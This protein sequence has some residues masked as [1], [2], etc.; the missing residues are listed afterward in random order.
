LEVQEKPF[1]LKAGLPGM[2]R[3]LIVDRGA[4]VETTGALIQGVWGNGQIDAGML[5]VLASQPDHLLTP[6]QVDVSLRGTVILA[7]YASDPAVLQTAA[8]LPAKGVLLAGMSPDLISVAQELPMPVVVLEGFGQRALNEVAYRLLSTSEQRDVAVNAEPWDHFAGT[9]PEVVIPLPTS[10]A[11]A[12]PQEADTFTEGQQVRIIRAPY[13]GQVGTLE[14]HKGVAALPNGL[15]VPA[16]EI[17]LESG[18]SALVP[19]ANLEV[20][21]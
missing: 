10:G 14:A 1:E 16:A 13:A 12:G 2:V 18:T 7:G 15:R 17:R 8:E 4:I 9:R 5:R 21:E 6:D 3:E 19:L 20:L 11:P